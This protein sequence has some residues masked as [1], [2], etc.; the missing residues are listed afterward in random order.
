VNP[1][2]LHH[3]LGLG[4]HI[5]CNGLVR[6]LLNDGK[7][8]TDVYIFCKEKNIRSVSSMYED[9]SRIHIITIPNDP[10][11]EWAIVNTFVGQNSELRAFIRSQNCIIDN[12][13]EMGLV[14]TWDE[15]FYTCCG[16]PFEKRWDSFKMNR[17]PDRE[18]TL[19]DKLKI[20]DTDRFVLV[21]NQGSWGGKHEL[22]I[23]SSLV[24]IFVE[25]ITDSM[26]DW[27]GIA[28]QAEEVHCIDSSFIHL[29]QGLNIKHGF[30]H[31][32]RDTPTFKLKSSWSKI[33]YKK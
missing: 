13:K 33:C 5:I 2:V 31:D 24:K 32:S 15:G 4:D 14:S 27:C 8:F 3:N 26:F 19:K 20:S 22:Q 7:Y 11:V 21:H 30:F 29:A 25:P 28:E 6:S 1:L 17:N 23:E 18:K 12:L 16:I 9:D 10:N